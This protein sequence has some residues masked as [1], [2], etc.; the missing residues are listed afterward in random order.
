MAVSKFD[1]SQRRAGQLVRVDPKTVRREPVPEHPEIRGAHA[2]DRCRALAVRPDARTGRDHHQL[3]VAEAPL[4]RGLA[5]IDDFSRECLAL[6]ADTSTSGARVAR[7][8]DRVVRLYVRPGT[9]VSDHGSELTSRAMLDWQNRTGVG[10]H[11]IA[12]GKPVRDGSACG[13]MITTTFARTHP[14]E[15]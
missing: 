4:P 3:Q 12:P 6:V 13:G 8:L 10:W 7:E 2:R 11:Y 5:V 1:I 15:G 14:W 9:I